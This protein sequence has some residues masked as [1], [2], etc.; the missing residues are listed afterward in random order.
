MQFWRFVTAS[1]I[2]KFWTNTFRN[3][4]KYIHHKSVS[5]FQAFW[6]SQIGHRRWSWTFSRGLKAVTMQKMFENEVVCHKTVHFG[7]GVIRAKNE[8]RMIDD[9][10]MI[11]NQLPICRVWQIDQIQLRE[12]LTATSD[13][14][15]E[16]IN[17]YSNMKLRQIC[18]N[19]LNK[20][21]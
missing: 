10:L 6:R 2:R 16:K 20:Y 3:L 17:K 9:G 19:N 8:R 14:Y 11:G 1:K 4:D 13:K 12:A 18:L 15:F 5:I 7:F 21:I